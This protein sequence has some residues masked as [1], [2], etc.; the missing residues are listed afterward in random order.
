[1]P[2]Q[3]G[4]SFV[5]VDGDQIVMARPTR[6]SA[7]PIRMSSTISA[8]LS[9]TWRRL[10]ELPRGYRCGTV[11]FT[12]SMRL[13]RRLLR[14]GLCRPIRVLEFLVKFC[15][16][17][18]VMYTAWGKGGKE[19][20]GGVKKARVNVSVASPSCGAAGKRNGGKLRRTSDGPTP[21]SGS[22]MVMVLIVELGR[23]VR[24]V[25]VVP[26]GSPTAPYESLDD[27]AGTVEAVEVG[28]ADTLAP[29]SCVGGCGGGGD[30]VGGGGGG[31]STAGGSD[32]RTAVSGRSSSAPATALLLVVV[33]VLS[34][35]KKSDLA[36]LCT[37]RRS[38]MLSSKRN[39]MS[40]NWMTRPPPPNKCAERE[41]QR[42]RK[43]HK[44]K[45]SSETALSSSYKPS[46]CSTCESLAGGI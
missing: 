1:M 44:H 21:E 16:T 7:S 14:V 33:V 37:E 35:P 9:R 23:D 3:Y 34:R 30:G 31:S 29:P 13:C 2:D 46:I 12:T 17:V 32:R 42:K 8:L 6:L 41:A 28:D 38:G 20:E 40:G 10:S 18:V 26:G 36:L 5:C 22:L 43:S 45:T 19:S 11:L 25:L 4:L 15:G 39:C 27:W 24:G